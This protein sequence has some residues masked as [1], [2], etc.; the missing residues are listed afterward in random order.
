MNNRERNSLPHLESVQF[1]LGTSV[2]AYEDGRV[3][4]VSWGEHG[5]I[6]LVGYGGLRRLDEGEREANT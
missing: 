6:G 3:K 1:L 4:I 5:G 2:Y